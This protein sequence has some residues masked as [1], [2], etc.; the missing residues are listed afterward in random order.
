MFNTPLVSIIIIS[1]NH[2]SYVIEAINS[3]LNQ[4]YS[5]I[6]LIIIDDFSTDNTFEIIQSIYKKKSNFLFFQNE[7]N[8]GLNY[9]IE[10]GLKYSKGE[11]ITVF[12]ADD[13]LIKTKT[14]EQIDVILKNNLDGV[15]GTGYLFDNGV[16]S[17]IN[18]NKVF[19]KND[20]TAILSYLYKFDWSA[21]LLQS[22]LLKREVFFTLMPLRKDF[23]LDDWVFTIK[24]FEKFNVVYYNQPFFYYRIHDSNLHKNYW[25]TFP[26]RID[27]ISR[28]SP[29]KNK[30][31]GLSNIF[32]SQSLYLLRDNFYFFS[33]RLFIAS[34]VL[35]FSARNVLHYFLTVSSKIKRSIFK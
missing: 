35:N 18:V 1:Y 14:R 24:A 5:S 11:Y 8:S 7:S 21:P 29:F 20:K 13:F 10:K 31:K 15:F 19:R 4:T 28:I 6:E 30:S 9:S 26:M 3:V 23:K 22:A 12:S 34:T 16:T 2:A 17:L 33:F 25:N 27:I 32:F